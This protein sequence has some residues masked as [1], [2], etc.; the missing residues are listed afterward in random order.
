M[1]AITYLEP[2]KN[3][4]A[5]VYGKRGLSLL[6]LC[7]NSVS[8]LAL[9]NSLL[10]LGLLL[11]YHY[12]M[13]WIRWRLFQ[14]VLSVCLWSMGV[15]NSLAYTPPFE[16]KYTQ[17]CIVSYPGC[18]GV[19]AE[20]MKTLWGS[21]LKVYE[22]LRPGIMVDSTGT[23]YSMSMDA[24]HWFGG[25]AFYI[26]KVTT[27]GNLS[28]KSVEVDK[29]VGDNYSWP[30]D[31][32]NS[33]SEDDTFSK[34]AWVPLAPCMAQEA[35]GT[36]DYVCAI[37]Y[38]QPTRWWNTSSGPDTEGF[39]FLKIKKSDFSV[40]TARLENG[41][42]NSKANGFGD[43][44]ALTYNKNVFTA[45][46]DV[47]TAK[48]YVY[49][50]H[51]FGSGDANCTKLNFHMVTDQGGPLVTYICSYAEQKEAFKHCIEP[52]IMKVG[53]EY[54]FATSNGYYPWWI[55][56]DPSTGD[57]TFADRNPY[58]DGYDA[59]TSSASCCYHSDLNVIQHN[60]QTIALQLVMSKTSRL[61][62]AY[63]RWN[64]SYISWNTSYVAL[65]LY[66]WPAGYVWTGSRPIPPENCIA[67]F[68]VTSATSGYD[69]STTTLYK[70]THMFVVHN[71]CIIYAYCYPGK[72]TH[73]ILGTARYKFDS[74]NNIHLLTKREFVD[75]NGN[76]FGNLT[77]CSR[78]IFM[79]VKNGYLWIVF[80]SV[81]NRSFYYFCIPAQ[82]VIDYAI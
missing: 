67:V 60:G 8:V 65:T 49:W 75:Q 17:G 13:H 22:K 79:D 40:V 64:A 72:K 42:D 16:G 10:A 70:N 77:N 20:K 35:N 59:N 61:N 39:L 52:R 80:A 74:G 57:T 23:L 69:I 51:K 81:D 25:K 53:N 21:E 15:V 37:V 6:H 28:Y 76:S 45:I 24:G 30:Y 43:F 41:L 54:H 5:V 56:A 32:M 33:F 7:P 47:G 18:Y 29:K 9:Q 44:T 55:K 1:D 63:A 73:L 14:S 66:S 36:T 71:D 68:P 38:V 4:L 34:V 11:A 3:I 27:S 2:T 31:G 19:W 48:I 12:P 82:D 46:Y 62:E 58:M 50:L 78:I 26:H